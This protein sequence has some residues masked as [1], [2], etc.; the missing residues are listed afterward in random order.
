MI[1][2]RLRS[3]RKEKNL[4]QGELEKRTGLSR[5]YLSR[6]ENGHTTP[7]VET[8]EK[9]AGALGVP[10][11]KLF[12]EGEGA[13]PP[14]LLPKKARAKEEAWGSSGKWASFLRQL[15]GLLGKLEESDRK[16][17]LG[18]AFRMARRK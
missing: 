10:L 5:C 12:Y 8:L 16:L 11:Y 2:E 6:L 15:Q 13:P 14:P 17:L 18:M 1:G 3:I 7:S 9:L 4:S